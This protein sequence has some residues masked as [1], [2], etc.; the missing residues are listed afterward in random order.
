MSSGAWVRYRSAQSFL[1]ATTRSSGQELSACPAG[2]GHRGER[3]RAPLYRLHLM[4]AC[5]EMWSCLNPEFVTLTQHLHRS[6]QIT[7]RLFFPKIP[8]SPV[9]YFS[10]YMSS[11]RHFSFL[12]VKLQGNFTRGKRRLGRSRDVH[13]QRQ[14][15]PVLATAFQ[16]TE[17]EANSNSWINEYHI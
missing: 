2:H 3:G 11:L 1:Q 4:Q 10:W 9:F 5:M 13:K 7:N 12:Y 17:F 6:V 14:T 15:H 16:L 8:F